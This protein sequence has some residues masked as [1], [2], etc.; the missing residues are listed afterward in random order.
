MAGCDSV[1]TVLMGQSVHLLPA[2]YLHQMLLGMAFDSQT[3]CCHMNRMLNP[4]AVYVYA[5]I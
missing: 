5:W 1:G 3:A 4:Y 2:N